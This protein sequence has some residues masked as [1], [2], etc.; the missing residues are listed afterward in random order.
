MTLKE[1]KNGYMVGFVCRKGKEKML[2]LYYYI[3]YNHKK[4]KNEKT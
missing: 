1:T 2:K 3:L 4:S